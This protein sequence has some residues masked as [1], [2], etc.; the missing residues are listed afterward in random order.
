MFFIC[1]QILQSELRELEKKTVLE[2]V[3]YEEL[4]L[5]LSESKKQQGGGGGIGGGPSDYSKSNHFVD[6]DSYGKKH[7]KLTRAFCRPRPLESRRR[8]SSTFR[9]P[10]W[11]SV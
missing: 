6:H 11:H 2:N 4:M 7:M 8:W 10:R 3:H 1:A 5:E 9:Q